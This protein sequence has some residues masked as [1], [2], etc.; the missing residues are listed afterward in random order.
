[1]PPADRAAPLL[2]VRGLR[3]RYGDVDVF[4]DLSFDLSAGRALALVGPNGSGKS[5]ALRCIT[6][7]ERPTSGTVEL[8]GTPV[9]E[10]S[11]QIRR[12]L[13]V[14]LD[15]L[16]FFPDLSVVEHLDL[17]ARA[18]RVQDADE[19]VDAV[20]A[21]VGLMP[22]A[23]QLPGTLSSGQGRRLALASAFVRPRRLLVLDEPEQRLD[24]NGLDWLAGR[25]NA[26]K[27][28]GLGVL[29]A[30]HDATLVERVADDVLD[31]GGAG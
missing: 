24:R 5:T 3:R 26:E 2:R 27:A 20:L 8:A 4:T 21:D 7:V 15:D 16:D 9:D 14:V 18:H 29:L 17:F 10:R 31:L 23:A 30:S 12:D 25:L 22:Q 28:Q 11:P 6:G 1:M 19:L 13:A